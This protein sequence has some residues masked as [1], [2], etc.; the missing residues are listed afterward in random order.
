MDLIGVQQLE[1]RCSSFHVVFGRSNIFDLS[2]LLLLLC[3]HRLVW[4]PCLSVVSVIVRSRVSFTWWCWWVKEEK[5][6]FCFG[7]PCFNT[8]LLLSLIFFFEIFFSGLCYRYYTL[9]NHKLFLGF[10]GNFRRNIQWSLFS[11]IW[12]GIW[13]IWPF[14][15][16][17]V[18]Q[19]VTR[20]AAW[21]L[22]W[23]LP[24]IEKPEWLLALASNLQIF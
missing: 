7:F 1:V 14:C 2:E 4:S 16:G 10:K 13:W 15:I 17:Y 19:C 12:Q 9:N 20:S 11:Q 24:P 3:N 21:F 23:N 18:L 22:L 8:L 5:R 6:F